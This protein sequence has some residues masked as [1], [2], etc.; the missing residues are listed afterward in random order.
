MLD[1]VHQLGLA[2]HLD[3]TR[4][5]GIVDSRIII[6]HIRN[7]TQ[8]DCN[9]IGNHVWNS[10]QIQRRR[11]FGRV[12]RHQEDED[13]GRHCEILNNHI[14]EVEELFRRN[15]MA[16]ESGGKYRPRS[17]D[18]ASL[19]WGQEEDCHNIDDHHQ[20]DKLEDGTHL[21]PLCLRDEEED[22]RDCNHNKKYTGVIGQGRSK[23][24]DQEE[25][26]LGNPGQLVDRCVFLCVRQ[27][28]F[29]HLLLPPLSYVLSHK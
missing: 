6:L 29:T 4:L 23:A 14:E 16:S 17:I 28:L 21:L 2:T 22:K 18:L 7:I 19:I 10:H 5:L 13:G 8:C 20:Q 24:P 9:R 3:T 11:E 25:N 1:A 12:C 26:Q 27:Y 15:L